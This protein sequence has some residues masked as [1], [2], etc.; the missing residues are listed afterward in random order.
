MCLKKINQKWKKENK[1]LGMVAHAYNP[2]TLRNQDGQIT[3]VQE[4]ET[5]LDNTVKHC[6]HKKKKIIRMGAVAQACN[7]ST[8]GGQEI[9]T[10]LVN[11]V[12]PRLY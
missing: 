4:F 10:I 2:S 8:L 3:W 12:K 7:P 9:E 5:S 11:K 6:L 1:Q